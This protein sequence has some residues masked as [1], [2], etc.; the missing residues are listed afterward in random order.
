MPGGDT[1]SNRSDRDR[2]WQR[3]TLQRVGSL[4]EVV[5][6]GSKTTPGGD[7]DGRKGQGSG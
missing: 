6:G 4:S 7:H 1:S 5:K 2:S 3:P